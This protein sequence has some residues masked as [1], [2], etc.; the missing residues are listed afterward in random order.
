MGEID[1]QRKGDLE[2]VFCE[3][4]TRR[5]TLPELCLLAC[6]LTGVGVGFFTTGVALVVVVVVNV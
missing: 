2:H 5:F 4:K 6:D 1:S 3:N